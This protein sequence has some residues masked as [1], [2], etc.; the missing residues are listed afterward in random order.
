MHNLRSWH[1]S[2]AADTLQ[3]DLFCYDT[4]HAH[5][6]AVA[7]I[8]SIARRHSLAE[9][10]FCRTGT[11]AGLGATAC[12]AC[13]AGK[14]DVDADPSTE[15]VKCQ[16]F[17]YVHNKT[18]DVCD[19]CGPGLQLNAPKTG[20]EACPTGKYSDDEFTECGVCGSDAVPSA[21]RKDCVK[22]PG[23]QAPDRATHS[24]CMCDDNHYNSTRVLFWCA[25]EGAEFHLK[26]AAG[27]RVSMTGKGCLPT[28]CTSPQHNKTR[29]CSCVCLEIGLLLVFV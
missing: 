2:P 24:T 27:S 5:G 25:P 17:E 3:I 13:A 14:A 6:H 1:V 7:R 4:T 29:R 19:S 12:T 15:C 9:H 28:A 18:V 10:T 22:C 26:C 11:Y 20:C 16:S 8:S 21:S 23:R